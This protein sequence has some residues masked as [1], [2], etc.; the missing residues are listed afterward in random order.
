MNSN[1]LVELLGRIHGSNSR[2][3]SV[4]LS[5]KFLVQILRSNC[6]SGNARRYGCN[7]RRYGKARKL[8]QPICGS[9]RASLGQRMGAPTN[10][11]K[12]GKDGQ[13]T[14]KEKG[15]AVRRGL[16][17]LDVMACGLVA[18]DCYRSILET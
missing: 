12:T 6:C 3:K 15:H 11:P 18:G 7:A 2:V 13:G 9:Q 8:T 1:R 16:G 17:W 10:G 5:V 14:G 4:G